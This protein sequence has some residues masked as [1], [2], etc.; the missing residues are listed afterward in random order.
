MRSEVIAARPSAFDIGPAASD[1]AVEV[2]PG[3]WMSEGLSNSF[4]IVTD[5]GRIVVNCGM[6]FEAGH[7]R[8]LFDAVDD[9][10]VRY[11]LLTQGHVDH[12]GGVDH[13]RDENTV[14]IAQAANPACQADDARIHR[15]RVRRSAPYWADAIAK[16][17][18]FIRSQPDGAAIPGQSSPVPDVLFEDRYEFVC[19]GRRI[20][21]FSVP[22]GET[23][24]SA[25][26]WLPDDR[27]ALVGN[28]FSAL[29]GHFPNLVTLRA[30][31][32][33]F[34]LPFI[35]A[36]ETV[37][38]LE[39]EVLA[40]GHFGV[41]RGRELI[42]AELRLVADAVRFV[43]DAT[44]EGMNAGVDL[45]TL[46][47]TIELP[48]ELAIGEGYG[49]VS[50]GV[51]AIWEGY[52]GWFHASSTTELYPIRPLATAPDLVELA[53]GAAAVAAA[54]RRRLDTG[55]AVAAV[56]LAEVA[57]AADAGDPDALRVCRDAHEKL[58]ADH[59]RENFWLTG[60]LTHQVAGLDSRLASE[61]DR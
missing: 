22:G 23:L 56:Q 17:D 48:P 31:R 25:V 54:A 47:S 26:V 1:E 46:M 36:V 58:L 30:D 34:A 13:F 12:V 10:P 50:W 60:W 39:P 57:L 40:T 35:A 43:H 9:G 32:L 4:L 44:V 49:K 21:L 28:V 16:A 52:A 11:I 27:V 55:D 14:L 53:G 29:F 41:L 33:R 20:E 37:V 15:F 24:D 42:A 7:H 3:V 59:D 19:G 8:R 6:G 51:R 45:E 2:A 18:E 5:D 38:A 61:V